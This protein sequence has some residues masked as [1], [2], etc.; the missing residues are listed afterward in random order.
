MKLSAVINKVRSEGASQ[1]D[2]LFVSGDA[3]DLSLVTDCELA[4]VEIDE[5]NDFE[6]IV[7]AGFQERGLFSTIDCQTVED[8]IKWAERLKGGYDASACCE[9]IRYYI[10][11]DAWPERLGAPDP[12]PVEETVARLDREFYDSLGAERAGT[13]CRHEGCARGTVQFSVLCRIHHFENIKKKS[14]PFSH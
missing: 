4:S 6:E 9:V 14:C 12:P 8:C 3:A 1:E 11:F 5:E 10:R 13:E 2:W 7:P